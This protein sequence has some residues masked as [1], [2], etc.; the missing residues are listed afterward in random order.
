[1]SSFM[2]SNKYRFFEN[3]EC[4]EISDNQILLILEEFS[5][6]KINIIK[7]N[8]QKYISQDEKREIKIVLMSDRSIVNY[9]LEKYN[10]KQYNCSCNILDYPLYRLR[11]GE[12][13]LYSLC[14]INK[15][16]KNISNRKPPL[17]IAEFM[18]DIEQTVN[19]IC[20]INTDEDLKFKQDM[21]DINSKIYNLLSK[22]YFFMK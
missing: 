22:I 1:M 7:D 19:F 17:D 15:Y 18:I 16:Q 9:M 11:R 12:Y 5:I 20:G 13:L 3:V 21:T 2:N 8:F 6:D 10:S 4:V 14:S